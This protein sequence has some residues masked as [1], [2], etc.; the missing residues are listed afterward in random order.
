MGQHCG[1][2]CQGAGAP[3]TSPGEI[4][5]PGLVVEHLMGPQSS[6]NNDPWAEVRRN[7][8]I[9]TNQ[10]YEY[11]SEYEMNHE[12]MG[13]APENTDA[14]QEGPVAPNQEYLRG[15]TRHQSDKMTGSSLAG[16][17]GGRSGS[18]LGN[19]TSASSS[20]GEREHK[21][22][23]SFT[24]D[25]VP[26][27]KSRLEA[28]ADNQVVSKV[29]AEARAKKMVQ[30]QQTQ[31]KGPGLAGFRGDT[32]TLENLDDADTGL[33]IGAFRGGGSVNARR[34][35]QVEL[36][37]AQKLALASAPTADWLKDAVWAVGPEADPSKS[38]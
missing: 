21:S 12:D 31:L 15:Q 36:D 1:S 9:H 30:R 7:E 29:H 16:F 25:K 17:R 24:N 14:S 34:R 38:V 37:E 13:H 10:L 4:C 28:M 6:D 32:R 2:R 27:E 26:G 3:W 18:M 8:T 11:S 22:V 5:G 19:S 20:P 23:V 35:S 33:S